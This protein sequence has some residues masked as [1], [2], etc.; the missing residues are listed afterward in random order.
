MLPGK[1]QLVLRRFEYCPVFVKPAF[2]Q[3]SN[4][5]IKSSFSLDIH[6]GAHLQAFECSRT[7]QQRLIGIKAVDSGNVAVFDEPAQFSLEPVKLVDA[8]PKY[9]ADEADKLLWTASYALSPDQTRIA[10]NETDIDRQVSRIYARSLEST[11]GDG[12]DLD[13]MFETDSVEPGVPFA[14]QDEL[15]VLYFVWLP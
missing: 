13:V 5:N 6:T 7:N 14:F 15:M 8:E 11:A 9:V 1:I 4:R 3:K 12:S 2:I 10:W